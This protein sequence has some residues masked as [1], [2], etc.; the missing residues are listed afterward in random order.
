MAD[1]DK[2]SQGEIEQMSTKVHYTGPDYSKRS[3]YTGKDYS[4]HTPYS[5]HD[6][7]KQ[8]PYTGPD[9]SERTGYTGKDYSQKTPYTGP[10]YSQ[11][12]NALSQQQIEQMSTKV[13]YAG[14]DYSKPE[15]DRPLPEN[16]EPVA[17]RPQQI[18]AAPP[19]AKPSPL[20]P[21]VPYRPQPQ[22]NQI[23]SIAAAISATIASAAGPTGIGSAASFG[24]LKMPA[25]G[26]TKTERAWIQ[27]MI[28]AINTARAV[29]GANVSVSENPGGGSI[30][31]ARDCAICR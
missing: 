19:P 7:S 14:P 10:D 22:V 4:Q 17:D 2:L 6:Y 5:G 26:F 3:S 18:R 11:R 30:I 15:S 23:G 28:E 27:Q 8:T 25:K 20:P 29:P 13:P 31:N 9:Y 24:L 12:T 16:A 1:D 21:P